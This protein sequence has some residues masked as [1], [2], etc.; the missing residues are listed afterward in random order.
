MS[1]IDVSN[2]LAQ[3]QDV[4]NAIQSNA[5]A[6]LG[7]KTAGQESYNALADL[8]E[9]TS[10]NQSAIV[11]AQEA[12]KAEAQ[13]KAISEAMALGA[14]PATKAKLA[15][16]M[17]AQYTEARAKLDTIN[18]KQ[19]VG[20]F[21]NPLE[22]ID[23]LF[24]IG[25]DVNSYNNSVDKYN[26]SKDQY[27]NINALAQE[28]VRTETALTA[29]NSA[30][31]QAMMAQVAG[32][33]AKMQEYGAKL[34]SLKFGID[35]DAKA[36]QYREQIISNN[37]ASR[38]LVWSEQ[39]QAMQRAAFAQNTEMH[40]INMQRAQQEL[41]IG[42]AKLDEIELQKQA[43]LDN[44]KYY[45]LGAAS[46]GLK[47]NLS[48]AE[49]KKLVTSNTTLGASA[50]AMIEAGAIADQNMGTGKVNPVAVNAATSVEL[51]TTMKAP[52]N[53]MSSPLYKLVNDRYSTIAASP[54]GTGAKPAQLASIVATDVQTNL[55]NMSSVITSKNGDNLFKA[56]PPKAVISAVPKLA[57]NKF[58]TTVIVPHLT[59]NGIDD[60]S[61]YIQNGIASVKAG[62]IT[63][64]ELASGIAEYYKAANLV[65][66]QSRGIQSMGFKGT[67][68]YNAQIEL[69]AANV[70]S[71]PSHKTVDLANETKVMS[72]INNQLF[73]QKLNGG[74]GL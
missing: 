53:A 68:K 72:L 36:I 47:A 52:G 4:N 6:T 17:T 38:Q 15:A 46:M 49:V 31:T 7:A 35:M 25:D 22:Y 8:L 9:T 10:R 74:F 51:V 43:D 26:L 55:D 41:V 18:Q 66:Q 71:V 19:Q 65:T 23:N 29:A 14:D 20:F 61:Q 1:N 45:N 59:A 50:R 12:A 56:L 57:N 21:D 64:K 16:D 11:A 69:P 40:K 13:N 27:A 70:L 5:T 58:V 42:K 32:A 39:D 67:D 33:N 60:P 30:S 34:D 44:T 73:V 37:T 28:D 3:T 48:P 62:T 2:I 54:T 63:T 24:T